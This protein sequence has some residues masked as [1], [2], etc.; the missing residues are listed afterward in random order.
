MEILNKTALKEAIELLDNWIEITKRV[1]ST[2][3]N[4]E[5][6]NRYIQRLNTLQNIQSWLRLHS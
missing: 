2:I 3:V 6:S 5:D 4:P 1:L